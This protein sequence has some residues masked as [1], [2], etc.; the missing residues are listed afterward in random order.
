MEGCN[1]HPNLGC[2][3][4]EPA[5][6]TSAVLLLSGDP[7]IKQTI[8]L[9]KRL[10]DAGVKD[11]YINRRTIEILEAQ[12]VPQYDDAAAAYAL[13]G[14]AYHQVRFVN[15]P[16]GPFGAKEAPRPP[17]VTMEVGAG[18]CDCKAVLLATML[19]T[20]GIESRFVT[21]AS[22]PAAP[23]SFS[24]I[25]PEALIDGAWVPLDAAR[26]DAEFGMAPERYFRKKVWDNGSSVALMGNRHSLNGYASFPPAMRRTRGH[27]EGLGDDATDAAA[28]IAASGSAAANVILASNALPQNIYGTVNT[29]PNQPGLSTLSQI[30]PA[31]GLPYA[32][33]SPY[34]SPYGVSPLSNPNVL[35]WIFLG[36]IVFV[37]MH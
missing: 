20:I 10:V 5:A 6:R 22:D 12:Q 3:C 7:G 8:E 13:W 29:N 17:R 32:G 28:V 27:R 31:T 1:C 34:A 36:L 16:V 14:Y 33:Y 30:N 23:D 4:G 37:E 35:L 11:P 19:G 9:M 26:P 21:V 2:M 24:H 15:D 25:Y 18:D